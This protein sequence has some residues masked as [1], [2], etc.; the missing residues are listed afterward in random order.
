MEKSHVSR[1]RRK[2]PE[3]LQG[4]RIVCLHIP[5]EYEF[6]DPSLLDELR[7]KLGDHVTLPEENRPGSAA[8]VLQT[9]SEWKV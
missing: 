9:L 7:A 5:D 3:V 1:L 2:F 4:K 8:E 6:M